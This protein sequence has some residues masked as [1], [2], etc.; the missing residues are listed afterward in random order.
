MKYLFKFVVVG[1]QA[2]GK[3]MLLDRYRGLDFSNVHNATI[4]V[5]FYT[6]EIQIDNN[7]VTLQLWDTAGEERYRSISTVYFKGAHGVLLVYD[8]SSEASF[9]SLPNWIETVKNVASDA[10]IIVIGNKCDL[11]HQ[12]QTS[13]GETFA[14]ANNF[15]F[16]E[17]SAKSGENIEKAFKIVCEKLIAKQGEILENNAAGKQFIP[18]TVSTTNQ[19]IVDNQSKKGCC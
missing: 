10:E 2:V 1:E 7:Q 6:K 9:D 13:Q 16:L 4:G 15:S 17:T 19:V 14:Q 8:V 12:I 18:Q 3:S 5:D 11:E